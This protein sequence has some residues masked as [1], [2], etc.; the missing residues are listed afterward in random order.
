MAAM[1]IVTL[2][3]QIGPLLGPALGR[4]SGAVRQLALDIS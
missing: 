1:T 4:F 2:P 3:G